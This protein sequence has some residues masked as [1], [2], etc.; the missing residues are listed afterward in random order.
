MSA[1]V[2]SLADDR[3]ESPHHMQNP[4]IWGCQ[5]SGVEHS[6]P[7]TSRLESRAGAVNAWSQVSAG[8][9]AA[10]WGAGLR[11]APCPADPR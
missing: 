9:T 11:S 4:N 6:A 5:V 1:T 8:G 3:R 7:A 2:G 10:Y